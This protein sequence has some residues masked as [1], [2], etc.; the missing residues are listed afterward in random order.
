[1]PQT[2]LNR[3]C[4]VEDDEDIQRIVR[5]SLERVGKMTVQIVSDP[6]MAIET[7]GSFK[8]DLVMLDW[9]MPKMDGPTLF[10]HMKER[11]DTSAL[12][13]VFITA[14]ASQRDLDELMAMGAAGTISKPFSPK[15][16]PE[17]L[18]QIWRKLP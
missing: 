18:R 8:P 11:P 9:M 17:Q 3:V 2:P 5:L 4:Y 10:R 15:D 12:P 6:T 1:M 14:K 13:V 7:M 16:L